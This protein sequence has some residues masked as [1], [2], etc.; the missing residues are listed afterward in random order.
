MPYISQEQKKEINV[1]LKDVMP[2]NWKYSLSIHKD[3][4]IILTIKSADV[5]LIALHKGL[6]NQNIENITSIPLNQYHLHKAYDGEILESL[7][8][9]NKVLNHT[10]YN[11]SMPECDHFDVGYYVSIQVGKWN[12]PFKVIVPEPKKTKKLSM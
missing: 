4:L 10:N 11:N 8:K 2:K 5:D 3:E 6:A 9:I 7:E 1:L 12:R